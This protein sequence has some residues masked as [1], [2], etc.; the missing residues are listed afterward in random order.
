MN[1]VS[2]ENKRGNRI[3]TAG[4]GHLGFRWGYGKGFLREPVFQLRPEWWERESCVRSWKSAK[5]E[6]QVQ[7]KSEAARRLAD[8]KKSM[9]ESLVGAQELEMSAVAW[10]WEDHDGSDTQC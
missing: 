4:I 3:K 8:G 6:Q 10:V 5:G 9:W 1:K 2:E 7:R